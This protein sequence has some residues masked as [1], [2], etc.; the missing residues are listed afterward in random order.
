MRLVREAEAIGGSESAS[1][2]GL[3]G[4]TTPTRNGKT[5]PGTYR[6]R[7]RYRA[8]EIK[9]MWPGSSRVQPTAEELAESQQRF[10]LALK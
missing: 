5:T 9:E 3:R 4:D 8:V 6:Y 7:Y 10:E 2:E 1:D